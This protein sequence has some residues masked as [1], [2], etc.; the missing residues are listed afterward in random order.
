MHVGPPEVQIRQGNDPADNIECV[1]GPSD[2][3]DLECVVTANNAPEV[4][5]S[6]TGPDGATIG[7]NPITVSGSNTGIYVCTASRADCGSNSDDVNVA[8]IHV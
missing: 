3:V 6:W 7:G 8:G 1:R 4:T 5:V 2:T